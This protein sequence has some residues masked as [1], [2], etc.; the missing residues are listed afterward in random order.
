MPSNIFA[1]TGT[2]VSVL[3]LDKENKGDVVL[4]DASNLG[5]TVKE[6]KNQKTV[7]TFEEEEKIIETFNKK[8]AIDDF[9]VVVSYDEIE[10]KNYSLSAGQY[11]EVKIEYVDISQ[12]EFESKLKGFEKSLNGL[13]TESKALEK[14]I[15][16]NLKGLRY[17]W[18]IEKYS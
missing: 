13:F 9:S 8:E 5:E 11:F 2:N 14:E 15:E 3:F 16:D 17:E 4:I 18:F 12:D 7:L 1:T 10:A 6:G